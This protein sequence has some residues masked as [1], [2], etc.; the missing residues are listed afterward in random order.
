[1]TFVDHPFEGH[2]LPATAWIT[3]LKPLV[4]RVW[5]DCRRATEIND[6]H[7]AMLHTFLNRE[8]FYRRAKMVAVME[9]LSEVRAEMED[10]ET[11]EKLFPYAPL[12]STYPW[13]WSKIP[14]WPLTG[15][16]V[17]S[18][19]VASGTLLLARLRQWAS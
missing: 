8:L 9:A 10:I 13:G 18:S 19:L 11:A 16:V 12:R 15:I 5:M 14:D 3:K 1:M 2:F 6:E 7:W 4:E 17:G